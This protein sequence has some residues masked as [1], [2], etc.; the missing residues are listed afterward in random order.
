MKRF[1]EILKLVE[2]SR[3]YY[4]EGL[5]QAEI[6]KRL[7]VSRPGISKN[8]ADARMLGIVNIEIKSPFENN[9]TA[10]RELA[11]K[12]GFEDGLVVQAGA[13]GSELKRLIYLSQATLYIETAVRNASAIGVSWG[14][15]IW[16]IVE[17]I[18]S[19]EGEEPHQESTVCPLV[20]SAPNDIKWFQTNELTRVMGNKS[21]HTPHYLMAP[22]F[23]GSIE[24]RRLFEQTD[25]YQVIRSLWEKLD[26]V[27][28]GVGT[29]PSVPD[30]ATAARF[31]HKLKDEKA[32]GSIATY[33]FD[34]DGRFI[35]SET[36]VVIRISQ[37]LLRKVP[38]VILVGHGA[39]NVD[40]V[41]GALKTGLVTHFVTDDEM[42]RK[43]L[44]S[45]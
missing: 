34:R 27:I 45:N 3:L 7:K 13:A 18:S 30:Q 32:V 39:K 31:G 15:D 25:E 12:Y 14:E 42:A 2:I 19:V 37:E 5:T 9:E 17:G 41:V 10:L 33:Y 6:S 16:S 21:A 44:E 28:L 36:D 23:P 43:L 1:S 11:Q 24:N 22:A 8:L 29:F 4:Q 35:D 40:S 26:L 38:Q 20:G